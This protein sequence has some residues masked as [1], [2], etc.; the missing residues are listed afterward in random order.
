MEDAVSEMDLVFFLTRDWA[1]GQ[2]QM[3][4]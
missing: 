4:N 2:V 3:T 1:A